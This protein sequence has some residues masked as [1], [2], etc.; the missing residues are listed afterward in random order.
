MLV[1]HPSLWAIL[2]LWWLRNGE[3][4]AFLTTRSCAMARNRPA[5]LEDGCKKMGYRCL[6]G[7][8]LWG[9]MADL[10]ATEYKISREAQDAFA[11]QSYE[12]ST[13]AWKEGKFKNSSS[14]C[15]TS[16]RASDCFEDE[17]FTNVRMDRIPRLERPYK[18][19]NGYYSKLIYYQR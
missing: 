6:V 8:K 15:T 18:G 14:R 1:A 9:F 11:V 3:Y 19:W 17:E 5:T 2:I 4:E 10:C 16:W 12:R 7:K 13:K